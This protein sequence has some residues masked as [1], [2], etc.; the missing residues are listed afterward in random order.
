M[1]HF[2]NR[3]IVRKEISVAHSLQVELERAGE[4][5]G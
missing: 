2:Y 1:G 3:E 5:G 4:E